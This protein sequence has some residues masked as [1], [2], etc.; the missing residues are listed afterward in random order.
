MLPLSA[1]WPRAVKV[2]CPPQMRLLRRRPS[3]RGLPQAQERPSHLPDASPAAAT[4]SP[5]S[6][7][8][9]RATLPPA[10]TAGRPTPQITED[11]FGVLNLGPPTC[12]NCGETHPANYRGCVRCPKP[13]TVPSRAA[14]AP[15]PEAPPA[16]SLV[17]PGRS[18]SQAAAA[19]TWTA[20]Q[21]QLRKPQTPKMVKVSPPTPGKKATLKS[22]KNSDVSH[23]AN[24]SSMLVALQKLSEQIAQVVLT[25]Q[26][27]AADAQ[28]GESFSTY[29]GKKGNSK[30]HKK[31]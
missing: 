5:G 22:T 28:D 2:Y 27:Q 6:A 13:R 19:T 18:F 24:I 20:A 29:T 11:A 26:V 17:K 16:T 23:G 14:P 4:I 30:V 7:P 21:K 25:C 15:R 9:P 12:A 10:Q 1:V 8:G 31:F 3:V